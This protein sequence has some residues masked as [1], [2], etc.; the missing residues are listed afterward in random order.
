MPVPFAGSSAMANEP[1]KNLVHLTRALNATGNPV[2][3]TAAESLLALPDDSDGYDL[4]LR[5][6]N[7]DSADVSMIAQAI[8]MV[9]HAGGPTLRSFSLSY[10]QEVGDEG[11]VTLSRILPS[12]L[13]EIGL[14][15][16]GFGDVGG[17]ALVEW[18]SKAC[19]IHWLCVEGNTFSDDT[20][21]R[22]VELGKQRD[23]LL[24]VV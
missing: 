9:E 21:N 18:A 12:T 4:H 14:V 24:V 1:P 6:A 23:G 5:H 3:A 16:C 2:C 7:V 13:T 10:N 8:A 22:L 19:K 11:V 20:K 17:N 15:Q